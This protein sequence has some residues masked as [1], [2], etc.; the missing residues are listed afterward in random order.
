MRM[1]GLT[2]FPY[3]LS[4]YSYYIVV[5]TFLSFFMTLLLIGVFP[6]SNKFLIFVYFWMYGMSLFGY[7]IFVASFF[8][9]GKVASIAGSLILF[10][11]AFLY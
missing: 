5:I 11:T 10:F 9:N 2:D 1:M 6:N 8:S 7:S 3:W 4:W